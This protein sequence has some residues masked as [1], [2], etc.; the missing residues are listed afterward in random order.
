M[1]VKRSLGLRVVPDV[2]PVPQLETTDT[3]VRALFV[4]NTQ[5]RLW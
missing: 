2:L 3:H 5:V 4:L 1:S